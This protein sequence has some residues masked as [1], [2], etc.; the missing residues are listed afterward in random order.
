MKLHIKLRASLFIGLFAM[1]AGSYLSMTPAVAADA[2]PNKPITLIVPFSAGGPTDAVAR[3]IAVPMG[4]DLG[5][6]VI[7]E[8]TV[9]AGGTIATTRV[10]RAAPDGSILYL[11]HMGMA[12]APALYKKLPFDPMKD[13]EYIGQVVDVPMVLLGRKN[14]PANNFKELEAY[15]KVNK[16]KVTIANAGPGSVSQLCGLLLMS[17]EGVELTTVP[18][19]GTGPALTD[20]LGGQVDLLCDQTTQTVPYIKDNLVKAYGVTTL[21]RLPGLPSIPTLD[22]QGLKGFEVKAWHGLYAPKGTPPEVLAK[23]N[24]ALRVALNNP[25]VKARLGESNIEVVPMS[26]VTSESLK[27]QL[28]SEI[29]KWGPVIR[30]A[31]A[32]AD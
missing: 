11:H 15:I 26:K 9:G 16:E 20:L 17:R 13:F 1:T 30:K 27:N 7:V 2:Y 32:Y 31:G 12:T 5:Q 6:T 18:Y 4:K 22:E 25:E 3:L 21:K 24:K 19:K 28:D 29:N 10:A 14:F 8:N 23:I